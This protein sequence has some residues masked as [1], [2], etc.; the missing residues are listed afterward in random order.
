MGFLFRDKPQNYAPPPTPPTPTML[1]PMPAPAAP[2]ATMPEASIPATASGTGGRTAVAAD[3][4]GQPG[5]YLDSEFAP[6][7]DAFIKYT[8]EAGHDIQLS[9]GYRTQKEQDDLRRSGRG[10]MPAKQSLHSAGLAVDVNGFDGLPE[11]TKLDIRRAADRAGL[12]WGGTFGDDRHFYL[13]PIPGQDRTELINNFGE[14][15][16]RLKSKH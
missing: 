14:Q 4:L 13:D 16:R 7:V 2:P 10:K 3:L 6:K 9:S 8:R 1:G 12:S 15:V 11:P 5:T